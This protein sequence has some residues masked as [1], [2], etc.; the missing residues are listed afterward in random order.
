MLSVP[1]RVTPVS[2]EERKALTARGLLGSPQAVSQI[3]HHGP[4]RNSLIQRIDCPSRT[5]ARLC[6]LLMEG[7]QPPHIL[8]GGLNR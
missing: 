4:V 5:E 2:T 7:V 6:S 1:D 3:R 8:A